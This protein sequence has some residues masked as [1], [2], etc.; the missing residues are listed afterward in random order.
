MKVVTIIQA[1]TTSSRLPNKV[2]LDIYGKSLLERVIEQVRKIKNSDEIWVATSTHAHDDIIELLCERLSVP[3]YRGS[4]KDVRSRFYDIGKRQKAD[5]IVR[6]TADNPLTNP[7]IA[8]ELIETLKNNQTYDYVRMDWSKI[9][10]G[11]HSEVFTFDALEKSIDKYKSKDDIEHVTLAIINHMNILEISPSDEELI[12]E[13]SYFAGVD[14]FE[15]YKKSN[16]LFKKYGETNTLKQL[17][18]ELKNG[19]TI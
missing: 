3:C 10:D 18:K 5:L 11:S 16:L 17:I 12:S 7:D 13:N 8:A 1:R 19:K 2:M 15:D 14:T 4:L 9:I 6:I